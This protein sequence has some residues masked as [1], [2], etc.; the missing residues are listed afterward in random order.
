MCA[1]PAKI[2][3]L[4]FCLACAVVPDVALCAQASSAASAGPKARKVDDARPVAAAVEALMAEYR[5]PITYEDP[6]YAY[7]ADLQDV[8]LAVRRDL[9]GA[10]PRSDQLVIVPRGGAVT[11]QF[12]GDAASSLKALVDSATSVGGRFRVVAAERFLHVV[13]AEIRDR[14]GNW[15]AQSSALDVRISLPRAER[16]ANALIADICAALTSAGDV[17]VS[18]M[19]S[20][21]GGFGGEGPPTY[22]FEANDEVARNVLVRA[23]ELVSSEFGRLS[24]ML[25]YGNALS[26]DN[27]YALN[28]VALREPMQGPTRPPAP[29]ARP[30][31]NNA[32]V[33][34]D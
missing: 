23:L 13:P 22:E 29:P 18:L 1:W 6:R 3:C 27:G 21:E 34:A 33:P 24:W 12:L 28:L 2:S 14:D 9:H 4:A 25:F 20:L 32:V 11:V 5:V 19:T 26:P 31:Q 30:G 10:K 8:T 15:R 7:A 16:T 17:R